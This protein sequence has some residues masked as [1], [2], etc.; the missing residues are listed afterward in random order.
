MDLLA[1]DDGRVRE[2]AAATLCALVP[3][4]FFPEDWPSA[5]VCVRARVCACAAV[6]HS[7]HIFFCLSALV[8]VCVPGPDTLTAL[9]ERKVAYLL[10]HRVAAAASTARDDGVR[11]FGFRFPGGTA[12]FATPGDLGRR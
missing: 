9:V 1:D 6:P 11:P 8:C 7:R 12:V 3:R 2:S 4:L 10:G 5:C